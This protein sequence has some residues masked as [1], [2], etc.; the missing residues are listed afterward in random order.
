MQASF[1]GFVQ[2]SFAGFV[3]ASFVGFVQASL[4]I[5]LIDI[6]PDKNLKADG[7]WFFTQFSNVFFDV[8]RS[9]LH[10][11]FYSIF[12]GS[13]NVGGEGEAAPPVEIIQSAIFFTFKNFLAWEAWDVFLNFP[14]QKIEQSGGLER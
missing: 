11:S 10:V 14:T 9:F 1:V 12:R 2:A 13:K 8:K 5:V 7:F 6:S 3:Q 4:Q